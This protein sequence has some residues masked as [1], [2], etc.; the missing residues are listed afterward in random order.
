LLPDTLTPYSFLCDPV[1]LEIMATPDLE[2]L[3]TDD[4]DLERPPYWSFLWSGAPALARWLIARGGWEET[5]VLELGCGTGLAGLAAAA[6]GARVTQ[7]DYFSE[8][9]AL[10]R[11]NAWRNGLRGVRHAAADW[12]A[13][14]FEARWPLVLG[15]DVTYER[16]VHGALLQAVDHAV[17]PG[18]VACFSDPGRPMSLD[19]FTQAE[20]A[21][22]RVTI[23]DAPGAPDEPPV[24]IYMLQRG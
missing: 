23:E 16:S 21:G 1:C 11:L 2:L 19:F 22:W 17:A 5:P 8:A 14:P 10:A 24:Y 3:L 4:L 7:T 15:S 18:G 12:R 20:T 13:W 9:V 6:L